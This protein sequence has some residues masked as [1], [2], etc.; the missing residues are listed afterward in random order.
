[1][2]RA[3]LVITK[4]YTTVAPDGR[5]C[6][7][8]V[9][10]LKGNSIEG[11]VDWDS[12]NCRHRATLCIDIVTVTHKNH[13]VVSKIGFCNKHMPSRYVRWFDELEVTHEA[14]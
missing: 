4:N 9:Q 10:H 6:R 7:A 14:R 12:E 8:E 1:M 3:G 2:I 13:R 5:M 11:P